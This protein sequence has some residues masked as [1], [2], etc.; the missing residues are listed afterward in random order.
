MAIGED[1]PRSEL[2]AS[3]L[4]TLALALEQK[5]LETEAMETYKALVAEKRFQETSRFRVNLGNLHFKRSEYAK[6]IKMYKMAVD[7]VR[8]AILSVCKPL[9]VIIDAR[10]SEEPEV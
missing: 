2:E 6:A 7:R 10:I 8:P 5:G 9:T 1:E 4:L 3:V